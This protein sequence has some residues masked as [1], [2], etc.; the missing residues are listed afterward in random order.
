MPEADTA[1]AP[2]PAASPAGRRRAVEAEPEPVAAS[3]SPVAR[4]R[5]PPPAA[6]PRGSPGS[7]VVPLPMERD[8]G[9]HVTELLQ[10]AGTPAAWRAVSCRAGTLRGMHAHVRSDDV[11]IVVEGKV[12]LGL[13]DLRPGSP[14]H[15]NAELLELSGR[16]VHGVIIPGRRRSRPLRPARTRSCSSRSPP[17]EED[18]YGCAWNDPGLG[19]EWPGEPQYLSERDRR[20]GPLGCS[21]PRS[22]PS[23]TDVGPGGGGPGPLPPDPS[24]RTTGDPCRCRRRSSCSC[25]RD[26]S[27]STR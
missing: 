26:T 7:R 1:P 27:C 24:L 14:T 11:R 17:T 20:A 23:C 2:V 4:S 6:S 9:G 22:P 5:A 10:T 13:K 16:R 21:A 18:E 8:A 25:R 15:G 19:I 3:P 12:A